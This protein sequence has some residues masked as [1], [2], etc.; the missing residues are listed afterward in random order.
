[1]KNKPLEEGVCSIHPIEPDKSREE[2]VP[3]GWRKAMYPPLTDMMTGIYHAK[4][5]CELYLGAFVEIKD[6]VC[7]PASGY[8][9]DIYSVLNQHVVKGDDVQLAGK[10][11]VVALQ[12]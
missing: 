12:D 7:W 6:G 1:M 10:D 8:S 9:E 2:L 4:A 5:G 3:T 11:T